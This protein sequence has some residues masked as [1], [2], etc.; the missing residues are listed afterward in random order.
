LENNRGNIFCQPDRKSRVLPGK[1]LVFRSSHRVGQVV[2]AI[3]VS[4]RKDVK[5]LKPIKKKV[6]DPNIGNTRGE[7]SMKVDVRRKRSRWRF[8]PE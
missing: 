1:V 7:I 2:V 3:A 8:C 5:F 6:I 4:Y